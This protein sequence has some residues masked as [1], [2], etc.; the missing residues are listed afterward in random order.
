M[1]RPYL[2]TGNPLGENQ[3]N[4]YTSGSNQLNGSFFADVDFTSWLKFNATSTV[5]WGQTNISDF[6]NMYYGT[7][8]QT[9]G[10]IAKT[11]T[12]S[13][14]TN[15]LQTLTYYDTYGNHNINVMLGHEYYNSQSKNLY[16]HAYGMFS[17]EIP[18]IGAAATKDDADSSMSEYNVEGYFL[19]AQYD[20]AGKYYASASIRRD[21]SSYFAKE[22]RW[23]NFWSV[24]AAWILSKEAFLSDALWIDM[25]KLKASIG[26]QGNDSVGSFAYVDMYQITSSSATTMTPTFWRKG[27][28]NL[29]WETTTN[30]N[31]GVEFSFWHGRLTGNIDVYN[32]KTSDLLFWVSIPESSGSRGMYD[33]VGDVRNY[34]VELSLQGA[35]IRT[36][37]VD[38]TI[39]MN[40]SHNS[41]KILSLPESKIDPALGGYY[42]APYF[43]KVGGPMY[44]Y[45]CA[46]YAGVDQYGQ[47]M[48]YM[49][50]TDSETGK[51]VRG[52]TY[53]FNAATL[54]EHGSILPK[55]FGGFGTTLRVA[56][57]DMSFMFDYQLGGKVFDGYY[58]SVVTPASSSNSAGQ[59]I[60][61]DWIKSWSVNNTSSDMPRWQYG[62]MYG[63]AESDRFLTNASYLNFQSFTVGY[64]LPMKTFGNKL[65]MRIYVAGENLCYWSA[66]KGLDPRYSFDGNSSVIPYSPIRTVSGGIQ[67]TF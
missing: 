57:F 40:V 45:Y 14:R 1:T 9:G 6:G 10:N 17:P 27:N 62:D 37:N 38:W 42:E 46:E 31:V 13:I 12:S 61:K 58:Q 52:T 15:H 55:V 2:S 25:L 48:F 4:K 22:N 54:Y 16:A 39:S 44:N 60:H 67:L 28:P 18:E 5:T 63:G 43:Y 35:L 34:G 23:G 11:S 30:F 56:N 26:Q 19:S 21:A 49:D 3:Y 24:G 36:K 53:D 29:T 59:T 41:T 33:N 20:Y 64:T 47:A 66:R 8:A 50:Q 65:K 7:P 51:V 32:K